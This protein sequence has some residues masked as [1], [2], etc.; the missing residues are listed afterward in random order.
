M[1]F[2]AKKVSFCVFYILST[3][4]IFVASILLLYLS[5]AIMKVN[6]L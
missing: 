5:S 3:R 6:T 2:S 4:L 1:S